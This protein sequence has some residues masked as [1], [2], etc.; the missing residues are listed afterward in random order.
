MLNVYD[1]VTSA[2]Y[3][4]NST[5]RIG[6]KS[7]ASKARYDSR[8]VVDPEPSSSAPMRCVRTLVNLKINN[9]YL[10]QAR[11]ATYWCYIWDQVSVIFLNRK[12]RPHLSWCAPIMT[13]LSSV[14]EE[15][16]ILTI[17]RV[18]EVSVSQLT[19]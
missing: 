7:A 18:M 2:E 13:T 1:I 11:T 12:L 4:W 14:V 15:P 9:N 17:Y 6:R 19:N 16:S 3:H 5:F 10:E 8:I